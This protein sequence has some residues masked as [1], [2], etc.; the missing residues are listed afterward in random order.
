MRGWMNEARVVHAAGR[1]RRGHARRRRRPR[2]RLAATR[3]FAVGDH[4]TGLLGVQEYAVV[5][6]QRRRQ[7]RP[8]AGAAAGVARRARHAGHDRLLRPARHR[9]SRSRARPV[10]VSGAAGAVGSVVG[11]IA[12]IKGCRAVGIAGGPREVR[13][14]WSTSSASTPRSTTR[15]RTSRAAL[16]EHCPDGIDVYFDNVGGEI[17]DAALARLALRRARGD[18]RR[19]LAVQLDRGDARAGELHVAA[20]QPRDA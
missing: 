4:V 16:R 2:G 15:T 11:Q 9:R 5:D 8:D 20:G 13:A 12:K 18:L 19:D 6:G 1:H 17:L 3:G 14:S 10:V 7:G